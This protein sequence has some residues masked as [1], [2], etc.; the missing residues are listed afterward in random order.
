MKKYLTKADIQLIVY[1]DQADNQQML[2]GVRAKDELKML[3]ILKPDLLDL[4]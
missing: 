1:L 2:R 3:T 4:E